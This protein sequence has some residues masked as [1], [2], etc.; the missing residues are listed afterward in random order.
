MSLNVSSSKDRDSRHVLVLDDDFVRLHQ[1]VEFLV[2]VE[3][4]VLCEYCYPVVQVTNHLNAFG[5][6]AFQLVAYAHY[7]RLEL[8]LLELQCREITLELLKVVLLL[9]QLVLGKFDSHGHAPLL[10]QRFLLRPSLLDQARL[11]SRLNRIEAVCEDVPAEI[12][13]VLKRD[14]D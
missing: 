10:S 7:H 11:H 3:D 4:L 13:R 6:L 14:I 5:F 12:E 2:F 9:L 1:P 8:L